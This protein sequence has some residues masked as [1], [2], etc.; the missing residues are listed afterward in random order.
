MTHMDTQW[1]IRRVSDLIKI[2]STEPYYYFG[3]GTITKTAEWREINFIT[4]QSIPNS[5]YSM[6]KVMVPV[7][8][9]LLYGMY[10]L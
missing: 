6:V 3:S 1:H 8:V 4:W 5:T 7:A 2:Q 10:S 9:D